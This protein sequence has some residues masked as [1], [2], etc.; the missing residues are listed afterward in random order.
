MLL[1][2]NLFILTSVSGQLAQ[3]VEHLTFNQGVAGS[4]PALPTTE[5][6]MVIKSLEISRRAGISLGLLLQIAKV[7]ALFFVGMG[8]KFQKAGINFTIIPM[9]HRNLFVILNFGLDRWG[10]KK[11]EMIIR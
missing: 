3:L 11:R 9:A 2:P 6:S 4:N 10:N 1:F 8:R 5:I 7:K